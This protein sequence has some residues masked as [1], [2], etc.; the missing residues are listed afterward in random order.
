MAR[1]IIVITEAGSGF[2]KLT[3][4]TFAM[5]EYMLVAIMRNIGRNNTQNLE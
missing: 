4:Q 1:T 2:G 5:E 3:A